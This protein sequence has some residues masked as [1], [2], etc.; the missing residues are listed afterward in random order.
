M[1]HPYSAET[2]IPSHVQSLSSIAASPNISFSNSEFESSPLKAPED[3]ED[4]DY[5]ISH[6][7]I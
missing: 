1:D 2:F 3:I 4:A 5:V 7:K 6:L